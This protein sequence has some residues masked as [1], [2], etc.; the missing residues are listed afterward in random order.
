MTPYQQH[1]KLGHATTWHS[2]DGVDKIEECNECGARYMHAAGDPWPISL[3]PR[4]VK[5]PELVDAWQPA[6]GGTEQTFRTRTGRRLLYCWNP[7][8]GRHAYLDVDTD[9][10]L[11][12]EDAERALAM[13]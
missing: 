13:Y 12:Q 1:Q 2:P 8:Q 10:I 9:L 5:V 4:L 11:S 3:R 7:A 6:N